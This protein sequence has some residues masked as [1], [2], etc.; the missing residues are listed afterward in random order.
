MDKKKNGFLRNF[1][2]EEDEFDRYRS[3]SKEAKKKNIYTNK[4][5]MKKFEF[6]YEE[7]AYEPE[8]RK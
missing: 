8:G 7:D 1:D 5:S 3:I 6:D 2:Y 4:A